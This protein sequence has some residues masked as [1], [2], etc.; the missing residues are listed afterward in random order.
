MSYWD[1]VSGSRML[2]FGWLSV[3]V[4]P[5]RISDIGKFRPVVARSAS[6]R[7]RTKFFCLWFLT[8]ATFAGALGIPAAADTRSPV[9]SLL[10]LREQNVITQKSDLSCGA[11]A[12]A[13]L[14]TYQ[15]GDR[16]SEKEVT[17]GL[18]RRQEYIEHPELV[19][20]REGFSLLDLKRYVTT[21]GY[22]GIGYGNLEI[23]DLV[24]L[25]PIIVAVS[26]LGYNHFVIFKG[27]IGDQVFLADPAFGNR[28]MSRE[29]FDQIRID[30]PEIGK[31]G[32]II[33]RDGRPAPPGKL[34]V[35][36]SEIVTF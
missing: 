30:F 14:L 1:V 5:S 21:R 15:F 11:A 28:T 7:K 3:A 34:A 2:R 6:V 29:K 25:A 17:A 8:I 19:R 10:E 4:K 26:P 18:I 32:F 16:V 27:M 20:V 35:G 24:G 13:T 22:T 9:R 31:I 33:T 36:K 23:S 12:L